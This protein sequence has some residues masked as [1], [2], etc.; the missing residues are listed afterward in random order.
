MEGLILSAEPLKGYNALNYLE[1]KGVIKNYH[2][3]HLDENGDLGHSEMRNTER[4]V[5]TF[6]NGDVLTIDTVC[7]G[8]LENT[9]MFIELKST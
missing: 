5:L 7:T 9:E 2:Y 8:V 1:E 3:L 4:L 6:N